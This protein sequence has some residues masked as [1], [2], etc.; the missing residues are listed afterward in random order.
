LKISQCK[1]CKV[2]NWDMS[3]A[4]INVVDDDESIRFMLRL[5]LERTGYDVV[6]AESG[7]EC[8][9]KFDSVR[10]DLILLD[11][12]MTGIDGWDVCKQIKERIPAI[13]V[14]ISLLS[15]MK[16]EE[17]LEPIRKVQML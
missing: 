16:T 2:E 7:E 5:M 4:L 11:I 15:G 14:P 12:K 6:E 10:P 9:E 13:L 8:L 1:H 3:N 17:D